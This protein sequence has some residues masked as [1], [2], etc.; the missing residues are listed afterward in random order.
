METV[1]TISERKKKKINGNKV[2]RLFCESQQMAKFAGS[3]EPMFHD[4][5]HSS[6]IFGRGE[7]IRRRSN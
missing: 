5:L 3:P 7:G 6:R 2:Q 4:E 1:F